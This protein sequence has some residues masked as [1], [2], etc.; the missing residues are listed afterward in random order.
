VT[1]GAD[2]ARDVLLGN[3]RVGVGVPLDGVD[4]VAISARWGEQVAAGERLAVNAGVE[5]VGDFGM[6]PAAGGCDSDL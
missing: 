6:A 4:A 5:S 1:A 2:V 3:G